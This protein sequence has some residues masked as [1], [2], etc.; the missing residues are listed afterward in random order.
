MLMIHTNN[1]KKIRSG[2][3]CVLIGLILNGCSVRVA[4]LTLVSTK[5][6]D[7]SD[8]RLNIKEGKR[9]KGEDC[10]SALF[11]LIPL[12]IPNLESAIDNALA[13]GGGNIMVDQVTYV[14][15]VY[16]ILASTSCIEVEGTVINVADK[17]RA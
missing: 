10:A 8:T 7:L 4:D 5:N 2:L 9:A 13:R 14:S 11:G 16:F 6:V 15:D 1:V 17:S 12:G 3:F